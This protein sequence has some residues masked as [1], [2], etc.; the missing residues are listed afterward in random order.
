MASPR[1]RWID[2]TTEDFRAPD[3]ASWIAVLPVAAVE[4]HGPHLPVGVDAM[5]GQGYLDRAQALIPDDLPVVFLPM[6]SIGTS[7]E[8]VAFPGTL[9]MSPET[10]MRAWI[11]IGAS[12]ARAGLRKIVLANSHGGNAAVLDVVARTLRVEHRMVAVTTSWH[13]LGYPENLFSA[14]ELRHGIHAGEIETSLMQVFR[15][16][17]VRMEKAEHFRSATYEMER[18]FTHLRA[19]TPAALGWMSQDLHASG[20][21]G[22]AAAATEAAGE[23]AAE[24]GARAFVELLRDV[25]RFSPDRLG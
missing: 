10:V 7:S 22:N 6:Q 16:D 25:H 17:T 24:F 23:A 19:G 20:A 18:E 3:V 8:H 11:E 2:M 12:V 9:T 15:P 5:I 14:E 21:I 4:Q 13:R 1:R